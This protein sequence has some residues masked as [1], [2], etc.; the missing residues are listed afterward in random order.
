MLNIVTTAFFLGSGLSSFISL[1]NVSRT[2]S[3]LAISG[4]LEHDQDLHSTSSIGNAEHC[5]GTSLRSLL[6]LALERD[7]DKA[8][9]TMHG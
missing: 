4:T 9:E 8:I 2:M 3:L 5:L 6:Y 7:L 1:S